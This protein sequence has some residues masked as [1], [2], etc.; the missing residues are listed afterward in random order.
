MWHCDGV[1][2]RGVIGRNGLPDLNQNGVLFFGHLCLSWIAHYKYHVQAYN[3]YYCSPNVEFIM[4]KCRPYYLPRELTSIILTAVYIPPD[5]NA[6]LAMKE[7]YAAISKHQTKHH[8]EIITLL[9][10]KVIYPSSCVTSL[11]VFPDSQ[12]C[13]PV[14][15]FILAS[16]L[17]QSHSVL[18]HCI[19]PDLSRE[20]F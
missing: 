9:S 2:W 11:I 5:A 4:V 14:C 19:P 3:G 13:P 6:K 18:L 15:T 16:P 1:T 8:F 20:R 12:L 17:L 10:F 7:L